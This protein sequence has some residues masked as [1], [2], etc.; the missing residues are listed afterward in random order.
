MYVQ[1]R[2]GAASAEIAIPAKHPFDL[3][4]LR[5]QVSSGAH[6]GSETL[7]F[8]NGEHK[9]QIQTSWDMRNAKYDAAD[10]QVTKAEKVISR[11]ECKPTTPLGRDN[12]GLRRLITASG[13]KSAQ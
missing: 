12:Q 8:S 1:Y 11:F 7:V 10:I 5:G 4:L 9:Y 3:G 13:I 2:F 6:G